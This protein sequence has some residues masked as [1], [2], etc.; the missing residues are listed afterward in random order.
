VWIDDAPSEAAWPGY[1]ERYAA[2]LPRLASLPESASR[3]CEYA[4]RALILREA[5]GHTQDARAVAVCEAVIALC[6]RVVAGDEPRADEWSMVR[7]AARAAE[8]SAAKRAE[9]AV[10]LALEET[11]WAASA[12][13]AS[14]ASAA[15]SV[16]QEWATSEEA[17]WAA[18]D[19]IVDGILRVLESATKGGA[20]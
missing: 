8:A 4:V 16:T 15:W 19:R 1:V 14:A 12:A 10:A 20:L 3:T 18:S 11:L 7:S 5:C 13:A 6:D 2:V 17:A 9:R